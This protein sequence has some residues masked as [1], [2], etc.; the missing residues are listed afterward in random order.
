MNKFLIVRT[1]VIALLLF[2]VPMMLFAKKKNWEIRNINIAG[3]VVDSKTLLPIDAADIYGGDEKLLGKTD[4]KGYFKIALSY[5]APGEMKFKIKISKKGYDS[6]IQSEHWGNLPNGPKALMYFGLDKTG[7]SASNS[8]SKLVNN[9]VGDLEYDDVLRNFEKIKTGKTFDDKLSK[10]KASNQNVLI[11]VDD[12]FYIVDKT[13][14][15]ALSSNKDSILINKKQLV[16]ADQLNCA[17][18]RKNIKWMTP[19]NST[20]T[21]FAI[22]TK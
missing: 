4:A 16:I 9:S 13:G 2:F 7:S 1:S 15:I 21:K 12:K 3:L 8:F 18:K 11:K 5:P 20:N 6:I 10:A 14:W 19:L 17:I 22:Y